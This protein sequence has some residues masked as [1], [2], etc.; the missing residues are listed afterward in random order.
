MADDHRSP[1]VRPPRLTCDGETTEHVDYGIPWQQLTA[2]VGQVL[3]QQGEAQALVADVEA[4]FAEARR[5][6]PELAGATSAIATPYEGI[7]I[8]RP[9]VANTRILAD[10]GLTF[11][12]GLSEMV[13]DADGATLSP[14]RVDLLH[15]DA[16]VWLDAHPGQGPLAE[17]L[18]QQLVVHEQGREVFLDSATTLGGAMSFSSVLSLPVV[19]DELVPMLAAAADGDPDTKV[20]TP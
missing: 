15:V 10:L 18:Y 2:T 17:P 5:E 19:L 11:P 1:P 13:G 16:L 6:H 14:E 8:Y 9:D 4:Q 7:W 12:S 3:G 20:P